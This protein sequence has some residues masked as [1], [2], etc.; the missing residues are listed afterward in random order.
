[1]GRRQ[2]FETVKRGGSSLL[3]IVVKPQDVKRCIPPRR[4][5]LAGISDGTVIAAPRHIR[6]LVP[7]CDGISLS[8][9]KF[10]R[11]L[12]GQILHGSATTTHAI[13]AA[14]QHSQESLLKELSKHYGLNQKTVAKWKKRAS[15]TICR[16]GQRSRVRRCLTVGRKPLSRSRSG[17]IPC[18]RLDDCLYA[19][20]A[21][22]PA[23]D[24]LFIAPLSPAP[25]HQPAA[26]CRGRQACEEEVQALPDRLL[27]YRYRRS[28]DRRGQALSLRGH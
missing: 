3:A 20:Q 13:R 11:M 18:C 14:I 23:S 28:P 4:L 21:D 8:D 1:M 26:G 16:Q 9:P 2:L 24:P 10:G 25:R 6:C 5:I 15:S 17:G 7:L 22:D 19:L 12:M 27:P